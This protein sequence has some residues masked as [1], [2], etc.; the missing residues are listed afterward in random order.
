MFGPDHSLLDIIL[1]CIFN[2]GQ[3]YTQKIRSKGAMGRM[4]KNFTNRVTGAPQ[5]VGPRLF[6]I[7]YQSFSQQQQCGV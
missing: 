3:N 4:A 2:M 6:S 7:L 5:V 1:T